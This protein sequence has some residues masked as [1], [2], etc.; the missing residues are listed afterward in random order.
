MELSSFIIHHQA[1]FDFEGTIHPALVI[2]WEKHHILNV[3]K[4]KGLSYI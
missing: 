2:T 4:R 1:L 3:K